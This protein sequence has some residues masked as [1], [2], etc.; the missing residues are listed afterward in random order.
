[1]ASFS[2]WRRE[3]VAEKVLFVDDEENILNSVERIFS[4]SGVRIFTACSGRDAIHI[5]RREDIA[6]LVSDN[7]MPGM[8]GIELF[9]K[10]RAMSSDTVR[11]LMTAYADLPTAID[12]INKGEVF[13]F[14]VKPWENDVLIST[15]REGIERYRLV[16]SLRAADEATLRSLG[17]TIELKDPYTRGHCDRVARYALKIA[18]ALDL[19]ERRRV[20]IKHG[21]WL[22]DCGKIG[23]PESIL[24]YHGPLNDEEREI[25]RKHP[26]WGADVARQANLSERIV[27]IILYHH[28]KFGGGGYPTGMGGK[29]IPLEAR[30]VAVADTFDAITSDRPYAKSYETGEA[31]NIL[32]S[33][34]GAA[35]D[36]EIVDIFIKLLKEDY[37]EES[38]SRIPEREAGA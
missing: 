3:R 13:R 24:N 17:Q 32:L 16:R 29:D 34:R 4:D 9:S 5:L 27:N 25:T 12:A 15:V 36:P 38:R 7:L 18:G 19:D 31:L 22:H 33:L 14:I 2:F 23:V 11:V 1:V 21:S 37:T 10:A 26:V 35:L 30:I 20:E 8:R 6:V 28:E